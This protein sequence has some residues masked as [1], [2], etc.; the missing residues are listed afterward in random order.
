MDG[1]R[2]G[3]SMTI[4]TWST[5]LQILCNKIFIIR[6]QIWDDGTSLHNASMYLQYRNCL[7]MHYAGSEVLLRS[8]RC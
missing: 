4:R 2:L 6:M 1:G 3:D 7:H 5:G 8:L